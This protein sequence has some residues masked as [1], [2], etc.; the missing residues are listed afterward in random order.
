M[1]SATASSPA[2]SPSEPD[3]QQ[4]QAFSPRMVTPGDEQWAA[5]ASSDPTATAP[6]QPLSKSAA[7]LTPPSP[8]GR[9]AETSTATAAAI[10]AATTAPDAWPSTSQ[11]IEI[12][13]EEEPPESLRG[14]FFG[15]VAFILILIVAAV[16]TWTILPDGGLRDTIQG[17]LD[18]IPF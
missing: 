13:E 5:P 3:T 9:D 10:P 11:N 8:N 12:L 14:F 1:S 7:P 4:T 16:F 17:W 2:P 6:F 15:V 18:A